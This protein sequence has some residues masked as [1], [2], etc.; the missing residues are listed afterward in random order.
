[1]PLRTLVESGTGTG[2]TASVVSGKKD[3]PRGLVTYVEP[4]RNYEP[5]SI[6]F[7]NLANGSSMSVNG[8]T[9]GSSAE[10]IHDGGDTSAWTAST[11]SGTWDFT[12]DISVTSANNND[13]ALFTKATPFNLGT[14]P[15]VSMS[16]AVTLGTYS[17]VQNTILL[18]YRLAGTNLGNQLELDTYI[19][20]G[21]ISSSQSFQISLADFGLEGQTVDE[22]VITMIRNGGVQ[23]TVD[24]DDLKIEDT[25]AKVYEVVAEQ[26]N[27]FKFKDLSIVVVTSAPTGV[28][29][30]GSLYPTT[31]N[32]DYSTFM[33]TTLSNGI[34]IR[35]TRKQEVRFSGTFRKLSDFFLFGFH[36][37]TL[38][39]NGTYTCI[40]LRIP[41][42]DEGNDGV[43]DS[44]TGDKMEITI[45]DDL[46]L[47]MEVRAMLRGV[48]ERVD[49]IIKS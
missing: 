9:V 29:S 31:P 46:S 40:R 12:S 19:D 37:E 35:W 13:A 14:A 25:G 34:N 3:Y 38:I 15:H 20:T 8:S 48:N 41:F 24:F 23:P 30:S 4:I 16:G 42:Y 36:L 1:M 49:E 5:G 43:L 7:S 26:G 45:A 39:D 10:T 6:V 17:G 33:G 22:L 2:I 44:R 11:L 47:F 21:I 32:I 28:D 18:Q 27:A